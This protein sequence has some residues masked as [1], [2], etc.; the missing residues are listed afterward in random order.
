M[1][2]PES[3]VMLGSKTDPFGVP[4]LVVQWAMHDSELAW[5]SRAYRMLATAVVKSGLGVV[6]LDP[7]LPDTIRRALVPQG[8]HH[9]GTVSNGC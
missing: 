1:P 5:I 6:E 4:R 7:D 3:R 2:N 9:I 8:G